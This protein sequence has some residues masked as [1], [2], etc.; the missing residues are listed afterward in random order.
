MTV[1]CIKNRA[2]FRMKSSSITLERLL[3]D[4]I[5]FQ[6]LKVGNDAVV[7]LAQLDLDAYNRRVRHMTESS[8]LNAYEECTDFLLSYPSTPYSNH[9]YSL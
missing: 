9:L 8:Q 7:R 4:S 2:G 5:N 6:R 3:A 1:A